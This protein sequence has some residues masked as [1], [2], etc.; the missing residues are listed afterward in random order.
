MNVL[1]RARAKREEISSAKSALS[2]DDL[3]VDDE[4][5]AK[6][7]LSPDEN[8]DVAFIGDG[9][10]IATLSVLYPLVRDAV[11]ERLHT[12]A[13]PRDDVQTVREWL[14][15]RVDEVTALRIARAAGPAVMTWAL[16]E[17]YRA[18]VEMMRARGED[19][20]QVDAALRLC[21]RESVGEK[22]GRGGVA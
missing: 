20:S 15:G 17:E 7:A 8:G 21:L 11:R 10:D 1:E 2:P 3:P 12:G 18:I 9:P 6:S 22:A 5:S 16:I 14:C 4:L 19:V 13:A